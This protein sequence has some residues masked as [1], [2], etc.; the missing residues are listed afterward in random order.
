MKR[1]PPIH[2]LLQLMRLAVSKAIPVSIVA[3]TLQSGVA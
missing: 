2:Q 3:A 1:D